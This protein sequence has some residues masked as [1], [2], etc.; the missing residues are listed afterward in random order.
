M[1][2]TCKSDSEDIR[3][4]IDN[5]LHLRIPRDSNIKLQSWLETD[6]KLYIIEIWCAGNTDLMEYEDKNLWIEI[7]NT[8][9]KN[10]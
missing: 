3:I 7:L 5:V 6:T 1:R 9:D 4:Y 8:L 2:V 10:I